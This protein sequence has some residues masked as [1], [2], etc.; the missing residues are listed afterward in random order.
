[1]ESNFSSFTMNGSSLYV[2]TSKMCFHGGRYKFIRSIY[3]NS[4]LKFGEV[5][6][7]RKLLA[8]CRTEHLQGCLLSL[9]IKEEFLSS[10]KILRLYSTTCVII[11]DREEYMI[12][13]MPIFYKNSKLD[14]DG[15]H[16]NLNYYIFILKIHIMDYYY[17]YHVEMH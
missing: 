17:K 8:S 4:I 10:I 12:I 13:C 14:L 1:M 3:L 11:L 9:L 5:T 6:A 2:L 7:F 16:V 15:E